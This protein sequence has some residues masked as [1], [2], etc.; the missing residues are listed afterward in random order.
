MGGYVKYKWMV[1]GVSLGSQHLGPVTASDSHSN[2]GEKA[3][4]SQKRTMNILVRS[5][6][7]SVKITLLSQLPVC[8]HQNRKKSVEEV[9]CSHLW[10]TPQRCA[11]RVP[12][13]RVHTAVGARK[14]WFL[15]IIPLWVFAQPGRSLK[16][17]HLYNKIS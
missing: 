7:A 1:S 8:S 13:T 14:L 10:P 11:E 2:K 6:S 9:S 12:R 16:Y 3:R 5:V 4:F 17:T 15:E